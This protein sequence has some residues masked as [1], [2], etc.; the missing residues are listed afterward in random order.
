MQDLPAWVSPFG[1][2]RINGYLLLPEAY[3]SLSR[4]SSAPGAKAFPL[5][6]FL[7]DLYVSLARLLVPSIYRNFFQYFGSL[8]FR[9]RLSTYPLASLVSLYLV[10][11][12]Q[13]VSNF[14]HAFAQVWFWWAQVDS[15]HRPRAYQARALTS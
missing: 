4:P 7:L 10:L 2:P 13:S 8:E 1:N 3:R 12:V 9:I 6:S 14:S 11:K 5:R 15:N